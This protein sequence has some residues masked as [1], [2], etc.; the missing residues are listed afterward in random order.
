MYNPGKKT[1][2]D[3]K[4][5]RCKN[6]PYLLTTYFIC[7]KCYKSLLL[8]SPLPSAMLIVLKKMW[9][10]NV[11]TELGGGRGGGRENASFSPA[12]VLMSQEFWPG[13]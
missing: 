6:T 13:L 3:T 5:M 9:S 4:E 12:V 1:S 10:H 8:L 11:N 7:Y 2:W